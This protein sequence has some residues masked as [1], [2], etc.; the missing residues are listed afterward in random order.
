[1]CLT[2]GKLL[3][4]FYFSVFCSHCVE[5]NHLALSGPDPHP[6]SATHCRGRGNLKGGVPAGR[7]RTPMA[8]ARACT[9]HL[10][11]SFSLTLSPS[12]TY[13]EQEAWELK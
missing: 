11:S 10:S 7:A 1:M 9:G 3:P 8:Y 4:H 2:L 13:E 5:G 12:L 6:R